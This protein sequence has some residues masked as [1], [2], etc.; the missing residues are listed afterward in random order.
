MLIRSSLS[1]CRGD[2]NNG[3]FDSAITLFDNQICLSILVIRVTSI[4][5]L[6]L[7]RDEVFYSI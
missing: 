5:M 7:L 6:A 3:L 2:N 1:F 4:E